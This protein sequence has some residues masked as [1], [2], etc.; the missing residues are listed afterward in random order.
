MLDI[1]KVIEVLKTFPEYPGV[2]NKAATSG[3]IYYYDLQPGDKTKYQIMVAPMPLEM[4]LAQS[5]PPE[6]VMV[7][8]IMGDNMKSFP[9]HLE[10]IWDVGYLW[11][12]IGGDQYTATAFHTLLI[13]VA[14]D[15]LTERRVS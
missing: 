5:M 15:I 9:V 2:R 6:S 3:K 13:Y 10:R 7:T 12:K 11:G 1:T 4:C 8:F 14:D